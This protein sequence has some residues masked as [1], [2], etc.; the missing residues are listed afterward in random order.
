[1]KSMECL[2]LTPGAAIRRWRKHRRARLQVK[3]GKFTDYRRF[4]GQI[5]HIGTWEWDKKEGGMP[6]ICRTRWRR[7]RRVKPGRRWMITAGG[8][9][10]RGRGPSPR[11]RRGKRCRRRR[12]TRWGRRRQAGSNPGGCCWSRGSAPSP[13]STASRP[14]APSPGSPCRWR[15]RQAAPR[16]R[17]PARRPFPRRPSTSPSRLSPAPSPADLDEKGLSRTQRSRIGCKWGADFLT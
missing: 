4:S 15:R 3:I 9:Q 6:S 14:P 12:E 1:M 8:H 11:P 2:R 13:P 17:S 10:L 5:K 16:R 7:W